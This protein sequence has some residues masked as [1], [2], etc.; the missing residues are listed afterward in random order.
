M[1]QFYTD[2]HFN[3]LYNE[4][5]ENYK[6]NKPLLLSKIRA[7][8]RLQYS[9]LEEAEEAN[10]Y[11][12]LYKLKVKLETQFMHDVKCAYKY[13][14]TLTPAEF[15]CDLRELI[16][17][18]EKELLRE[19][20]LENIERASRLFLKLTTKS[21]KIPHILTDIDDTLYPSYSSFTETSG[22]DTS[23]RNKIPYP[24]IHKFYEIFYRNLPLEESRYSTVLTASPLYLKE[25]RIKDDAIGEIIGTK[26]G[27]IQGSDKKRDAMDTLITGMSDRPFYYFAPSS[28]KVG[29]EKFAKFKQYTRIFPEH[30]ILFIGDNGQ[31]D[32]IAGKLMI[33]HTAD[34]LVFIHN[35]YYKGSFLFTKEDEAVHQEHAQGRLFFF[36]NYLE[37]AYIFTSILNIFTR[38]QYEEL[39]QATIEDIRKGL[40]SFEEPEKKLYDHYLYSSAKTCMSPNACIRN[41]DLKRVT[42]KKSSNRNRSLRIKVPNELKKKI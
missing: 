3:K 36:K 4:L 30:R 15:G 38:A 9:N 16:F 19:S 28:N 1:D 25:S 22:R 34:V 2:G 8:F 33:E 14:F 42:L 37:L 32:L 31:G 40:E 11:R 41:R 23:W 24:G 39:K 7:K 5:K 29:A 20:L 13:L 27:Y 10:H 18:N 26:F 6:T 35:I 17:Y 12:L 21:A